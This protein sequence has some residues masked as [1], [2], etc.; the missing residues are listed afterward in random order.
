M[1]SI[2][3]EGQQ[4]MKEYYMCNE[5]FNEFIG[6]S[7]V[8]Q[9]HG[10]VVFGRAQQIGAENDGQC[11]CRHLIVLF[12]VCDSAARMSQKECV[13]KCNTYLSRCSETRFRRSKFACGRPWT[14]RCIA[15]SRASRSSSSVIGDQSGGEPKE[16]EK[17]HLSLQ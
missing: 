9:K 8:S 15:D 1:I 10:E 11:F 17:T 5:R 4:S 13:K 6:M 14:M 3:D 2:S 7:H 12:K 16:R